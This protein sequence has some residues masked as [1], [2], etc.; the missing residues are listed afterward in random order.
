MIRNVPVKGIYKN[1][2][3]LI[4]EVSRSAYPKEFAGM[5]EAKDGII[6]S[7]LIL[8][9][10]QTSENN[11]VMDLFMMPNI[12]AAGSVHSHP[13]PDM[14]PSSEDL[15]LFNK[16]GSHHIITGYPFGPEDWRCYDSSGRIV[17]LEVLDTP[18]GM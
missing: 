7:L 5:L 2:L 6:T 9:G 1:T 8:P 4:L 3:D 18:E 13:V 17:E 11:A 15:H 10:T 14:L 16:T 12:R